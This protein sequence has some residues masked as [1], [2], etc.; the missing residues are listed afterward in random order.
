MRGGRNAPHGSSPR[1][2]FT[3]L[4]TTQVLE[5]QIEVLRARRIAFAAFAQRQHLVNEHRQDQAAFL[6][7]QLARLLEQ[8]IAFG[9]IDGRV[10][11]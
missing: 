5:V 4:L 8:L 11:L 1:R 2:A 7:K 10:R 6:C 9:F 3:E